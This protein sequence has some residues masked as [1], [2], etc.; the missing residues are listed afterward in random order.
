MKRIAKKYVDLSIGD[1]L[2]SFTISET[3][4]TIRN[5]DLPIEGAGSF[6]RNIHTDA[7]FAKS[8]LFAGTVNAGIVTMAYINQMLEQWFP[9]K[10][11]YNGGS[12]LFKAIKPFRPGDTVIFTGTITAK[13][14][15]QDQKL[16]ECHIEGHNQSGTIVGV[17]DA[18]LVFEE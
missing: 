17:A 3:Q 2:P 4:E 8:G 5:A 1:P 18:T 6:P 10:C 12:L 16:V 13:R 7:G 14:L 11:F 15:E 9:A